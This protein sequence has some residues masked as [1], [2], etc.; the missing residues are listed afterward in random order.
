MALTPAEIIQAVDSVEAVGEWAK[1]DVNS[2]TQM[3]SG[4]LVPSPAKVANDGAIALAAASAQVIAIGTVDLD[5]QIDAVIAQGEADLI[6]ETAAAIAA[7]AQF[8]AAIPWSTF[9]DVTDTLQPYTES[10]VIYAPQA[11]LVPFNTGASFTASNWYVLQGYVRGNIGTVAPIARKTVAL[12]TADV[13]TI[14]GEFYAVG[15]YATNNGSS[16]LYFEAITGAAPAPDGGSE[17]DHDTLGLYF[18]QIFPSNVDF[19]SYGAPGNSTDVST[20]FNAAHTA[21]NDGT[22]LTIPDG[23]FALNVENAKLNLN[24]N[25]A[26][27]I[28]IPSTTG[29]VIQLDQHANG[30]NFYTVSDLTVDGVDSTQTGIT[31]DPANQLAGRWS[32]NNLYLYRN[33]IAL[34]R[35]KGQ[36]GVSTFRCTFRQGNVGYWSEDDQVGIM[37]AGADVHYGDHL[38]R[39]DKAAVYI[40]DT[41]DGAGQ[42]TW[43]NSIIEGNGGYGF[44]VNGFSANV[45][46]VPIWLR[47]VWFESNHTEVSVTIDGYTAVPRDLAL[48]DAKIVVVDGSYLNSV[49]LE[50]TTLVANTCRMD[51]SIGAYDVEVDDNSAMIISDF[52]GNST[53]IV[54]EYIQNF[55]HAVP[56]GVSNTGAQFMA[57]RA[58][59]T[60]PGYGFVASEPFNSG[61][62]YLWSGTVA[63]NST[64][65]ADGL[66]PH[67]GGVLT[68]TSLTAV[69]GN[70]YLSPAPAQA[71]IA[72]GKWN[73]LS[74]AHKIR[75]GLAADLAVSFW[76]GATTRIRIAGGAYDRRRVNQWYTSVALIDAT[77]APST[78]TLSIYLE[79]TTTNVT[80]RFC[81][82]QMMAFDDK[83]SALNYIDNREYQ[84]QF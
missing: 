74:L 46:F 37:H 76:D 5:N 14:V 10:G 78:G 63:K 84:H 60:I 35:P 4:P 34:H 3:P 38:E 27:T 53:S 17:I 45:P 39:F 52:Y 9:A 19:K 82:F 69:A 68:A 79:C 1:G 13:N 12:M 40:T 72:G 64:T 73:V 51:S 57:H 70:D 33:D 18:K 20:E 65:V 80:V 50:G 28:L 44:L 55:G 54:H 67:N 8:K 42:S 83:Q 36:I 29:P 7:I 47:Q 49:R 43:D 32:L 56:L 11:S 24:G 81:D 6:D 16:M 25:G 75:V 66:I 21:L 31:F 15:D 2:T 26:S 22:T 41:T 23:T 58:V 30:W 48:R 62:N 59:S 71:I 61:G 77:A